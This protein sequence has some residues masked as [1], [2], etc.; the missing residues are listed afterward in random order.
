[1]NEFTFEKNLITPLE[2]CEWDK[3]WIDRTADKET[4][5]VL[6]IGDSISCATRTVATELSGYSVIF[7]GFGSSKGLDNPYFKPSLKAFAIQEPRRDA[8]LFNNGLH[9]WHLEDKTDYLCHYESMIKFLMEEY[10]DTPIYVVLTTAIT[11][12][13]DC[14]VKERNR[15]ASLV[16]EKYGLP[17]IDIYTP[18][19]ENRH[20][21]TPDKIH[22]TDEGYKLIAKTILDSIKG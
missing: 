2:T 14:R 12:P 15:S 11:D 6:Y 20:L 4:K 9:G 21:V 3:T 1:M 13:W 10:P 16:A 22:L 17:I 19:D 18:I 5:R 7:D 8:I